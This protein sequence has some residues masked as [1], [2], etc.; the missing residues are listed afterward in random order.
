MKNVVLFLV[1]LAGLFV[2]VWGAGVLMA[3][4]PLYF[5]IAF[6][7]AVTLVWYIRKKIL[8]GGT[9]YSI[10]KEKI[11]KFKTFNQQEEKDRLRAFRFMNSQK[12]I[13]TRNNPNVHFTASAWIINQDKSKVLM[14]K[15]NAFKTWT[16]IGAH[17]D[18]ELD[19]LAVACKAVSE[20]TGLVDFEVLDKNFISIEIL[21]V[22]GYMKNR[23][24][25]P[26]HLHI[27]VTFLLQA[28]ETDPL[29]LGAGDEENGAK[30]I[31]LGELATECRELL[32]L[33]VYYKLIEK[34]KKYSTVDIL[35]KRAA[36]EAADAEEE[37]E[38]AAQ[39]ENNPALEEEEGYT[40][41]RAEEPRKTRKTRKNE[42]QYEGVLFGSSLARS[43]EEVEREMD[44]ENKRRAQVLQ[45]IIRKE[46][47][48]VDNK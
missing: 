25:E 48:R 34:A 11:R 20:K 32:M 47:T 22:Q 24:Y 46:H 9:E 41:G 15:Q 8:F 5:C 1:S 10:L 31:P 39:I 3:Q 43:I 44:E 16:W 27:N 14:I 7:L 17:A 19:L 33:P 12:N 26:A 18:G 4:Y 35:A 6:V 36:Q 30:W 23:E 45:D 40:F 37:E 29:K 42:K 28:L 13:M 2:A 38:L 21:G